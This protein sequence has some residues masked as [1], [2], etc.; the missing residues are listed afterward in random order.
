LSGDAVETNLRAQAT[1]GHAELVALFS[2][3]VGPPMTI[4]VHNDIWL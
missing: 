1:D 2:S 3:T 4:M